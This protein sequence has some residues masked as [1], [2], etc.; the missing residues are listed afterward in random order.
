MKKSPSNQVR[1]PLPKPTQVRADKRYTRKQLE[2]LLKEIHNTKGPL[3]SENGIL[4]V[5]D[6]I[7]TE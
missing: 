7:D 1:K 4:G 2:R 3:C 6:E 5:Y